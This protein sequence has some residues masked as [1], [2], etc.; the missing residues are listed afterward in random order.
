MFLGKYRFGLLCLVIRK[1]HALSLVL[2]FKFFKRAYDAFFL[3]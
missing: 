1:E 3:I 2:M